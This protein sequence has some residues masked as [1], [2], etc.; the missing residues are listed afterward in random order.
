MSTAQAGFK[1]G[2]GAETAAD[3]LVRVGPTLLVDVGLRSTAGGW[4]PELPRKRVHAL[5]DTGAGADGIDDT[6]ARSLALPVVDE[7]EMSGIGGKHRADVYMARVYVPSLDRLLFQRFT[8][9]MLEEGEQSHRLIL[10]RGFLR[11][12]RMTYDGFS[13]AVELATDD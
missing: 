6:L 5:I 4:P 13:G 3:L 10:G 8:G 9:V 12:Y 7:V 11:P 1:Q 2:K